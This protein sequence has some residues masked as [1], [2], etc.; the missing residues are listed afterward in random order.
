MTKENKNASTDLGKVAGWNGDDGRHWVDFQERY[1]AMMGR[2]TPYLLRAIAVADTD[3][4]LDVG[5]GCGETSLL[6]ARAASSGSVL[7]VDLSAA[8]LERAGERARAAG[9]SNV[10][11]VRADAQNHAFPDAAFDVVMSRFGVMFFAD[12]ELAFTNLAR[13]LRPGGRMVFLCW[14]QAVANEWI[15]TP[16]A[17]VAEYVDITGGIAI[18]GPGPFSLADPGRINGLLEQAGLGS[19]RIEPVSQP[20]WFGTDIEDVVD[21]F[22]QMPMVRSLLAGADENTNSA[23][24]DAVRLALQPHTAP[25]G[26]LL[27]SA[28]WLV[29]ALRPA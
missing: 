8:M 1:D 7:G 28:A 12:P 27:G 20:L 29:K 3:D 6:A 21:L 17:A 25:E 23:A 9:V 5:C 22:S 14:Q 26:V 16:G 10:E 19:I 24:F 4:V 2:L 11:F 13:A 15:A 18:G